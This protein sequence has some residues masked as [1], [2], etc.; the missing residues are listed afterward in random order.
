FLLQVQKT[1]TRSTQKDGYPC[2]AEG[3]RREQRKGRPMRH[4]D[5]LSVKAPSR[6]YHSPY[7]DRKTMKFSWFVRKADSF[8]DG[9]FAK[10]KFHQTTE[11]PTRILSRT[12]S[13]VKKIHKSKKAAFWVFASVAILTLIVNFGSYYYSRL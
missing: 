2:V 9:K 6:S 8:A 10:Q 7:R 3:D 13:K 11:K 12:W 5:F 1:K 4:S